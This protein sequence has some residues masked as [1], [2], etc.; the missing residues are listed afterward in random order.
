MRLSKAFVFFFFP[1]SISPYFKAKTNNKETKLPNRWKAQSKYNKTKFITYCLKL[2]LLNGETFW[3][4]MALR[5]L[6]C[7]IRRSLFQVWWHFLSHISLLHFSS[8]LTKM[9]VNKLCTTSTLK[10]KHQ[11]KLTTLLTTYQFPAFP[12]TKAAQST[13]ETLSTKEFFNLAH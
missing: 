9:H 5:K 8:P 7:G 13:E 11:P 12:Y 3:S 4:N 10:P 6:Q 1:L 2:S